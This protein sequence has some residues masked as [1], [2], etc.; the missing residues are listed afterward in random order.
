MLIVL[1][2]IRRMDREKRGWYFAALQDLRLNR[3]I[4]QSWLS[5]FLSRNGYRFVAADTNRTLS[6]TITYFDIEGSDFKV[7]LWFTT[8][9]AMPIVELG[10]GPETLLNKG[11]LTELRTR[12]SQ[13]I[14][15]A[16]PGHN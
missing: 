4:L 9:N 5:G 10:I 14:A 8:M 11:R 6:L 7:R 1:A 15:A 16:Y 12:M 3:D 2:K 13:E